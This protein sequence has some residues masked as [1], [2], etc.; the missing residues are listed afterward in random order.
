MTEQL[1]KKLNDSVVTRWGAL[2]IVAFTMMA[3]YY[4]NDVMAPLKNMLESDLAWTSTEFGFFTG[5]YSFLNVF[6]LMLIWGGLI[7]DRFG[8]RFTGKLAAILMVVGTGLEYYAI[9]VLAGNE[10][11][12]FGYKTGVFV[13]SAGYSIFGVGAEVAGITVSKIIAK[14]FRGKEMAT[15]MGVQVA[16]ARIGSQAA[17]SVAIPL[18]RNFSIDT[19]LLIGFVLLVGGLIAFFAFSVMDKKLDKQVEASAEDGG[20]DKFSFKDV[21]HILTN[22]GFWLIA[23]LCVL[24]Y[25]CVFPFQKFAS[26]LM[27]GK[28]GIDENVAGSIV[29]LPALGAL[30]LTPVFGG[31]V[32]KRGK[33][34]SIM[35]LGAAMLICV[36]FIYAIPSIDNWL[37]AIGLMIILGIAFS[38][39]PSA[40][41]PSV[42]KIFPVNQLGTA[43]ALIF[44]IQNIGLWGIPTLIG[45]VLDTY[46]VVGTSGNANEYDYTIPMCIFTGLAILSLF[47]A[48]LLKVVDKKKG[49]GLELPN[50]KK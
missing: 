40:M 47:V 11:L 17:Y 6:L 28:Y 26:E 41:W 50:I 18:A 19:P 22:P 20:E 27:V 7:L 34:A 42:A 43:Y 37:I 13:A 10:S 4:V 35:M 15:A 36:H 33:A 46:C 9:T 29:G 5:A 32:D 14:W 8:I 38:L 23:L 48:F 30:I 16:L 25:S 12:I 39:V 1:K 21:K 24:F 31:L 49:Y 45:W 3:A 2:A 44:F